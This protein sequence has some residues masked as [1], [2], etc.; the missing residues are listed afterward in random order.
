MTILNPKTTV[1]NCESCPCLNHGHDENECNLGFPIDTKWTTATKPD[2]IYCSSGCGLKKV[3]TVR[4]EFRAETI[5]VFKED[6]R[7]LIHKA[8]TQLEL[9]QI[10]LIHRIMSPIPPSHFAENII[11]TSRRLKKTNNMGEVIKFRRP[12]PL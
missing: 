8:P 6:P 7:R 1:T 4:R 11:E 9:M 2:L 3:L 10:N 5:E 12:S